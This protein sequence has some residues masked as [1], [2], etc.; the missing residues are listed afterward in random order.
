MSFP[1]ESLQLNIFFSNRI[2]ALHERL[3]EALYANPNPFVKRFVIVPNI[4]VKNWL[5]METAK[6]LGI[7]AGVQFC[8]FQEILPRFFPE[9]KIPSF[10]E[11]AL[12]VELEIRKGVNE[13]ASMLMDEQACWMPVMHYL[14]IDLKSAFVFSRKS[15]KRL[16]RFS[17]QIA[18]LFQNYMVYGN[19][20][21]EDWEGSSQNSHW[22]Q[23]LWRKI[24][25]S[26]NPLAY[27]WQTPGR[28][29]FENIPL[30]A[31][32]FYEIHFFATSYLSKNDFRFLFRLSEI[33]PVN[34]YLLSPCQLFWSD[35]LTDKEKIFLF[36]QL[37][38]KKVSELQEQALEEFLRD[39]N[40]LLVNFGRL[41]R[42]MV[43]HIEIH[44]IPV[45]SFYVLPQTIEQH[46]CYRSLLYGDTFL[47]PQ[48]HS[49]TMLQAVQA[50]MVLMRPIEGQKLFFSDK[51]HSIQVHFSPSKLREVENLYEN[52]VEIIDRHAGDELPIYP[53][54]ILVMA[55]DIRKYAPF[56]KTV[57][58]REECR[59][60][61]Q[62]ADLET[63]FQ[64]PK[65]Q[66]FFHLLSLAFGR[67]DVI[68]VMHLFDF[69]DFLEKHQF[70]EDDIRHVRKW[71]EE[72]NVKWGF[73]PNHRNQILKRN[74]CAQEIIDNY[75]SGTWVECFSRLLLGIAMTAGENE[76][77]LDQLQQIPLESI[78]ISK[79]ELAGKW[80]CLL[81][82]LFEDLKKLAEGGKETWENWTRHLIFIARKYAVDEDKKEDDRFLLE[83]L[84]AF[85]QKGE[86][87]KDRLFS[88]ETVHHHL[89]V[90][91]NQCSVIYHEAHVSAVRFCSM[92]PMRAIPSRV[93]ILLGMEEGAFPKPDD[94]LSLNLMKE[95]AGVG[96]FP[97]Q[98]DYDRF[99]F[100]EILLSA[101]D[102]LLFSYQGISEGKG[103]EP[104]PSLVVAE[105][106]SYLDQCYEIEGKKISE[107]R[108]YKHPLSSYDS[109]YFS[110]EKG[111]KCSSAVRYSAARTFYFP[112][113]TPNHKFIPC[114]KKEVNGQKE[115]QSE[116]NVFLSD[117][118][119][120][121]RNPI[122]VYFNKTLGMYLKEEEE[123][124]ADEKFLLSS[125]DVY[126]MRKE[127][128]YKSVDSTISLA[129][130]RGNFPKGLFKTIA[131]EKIQCEASALKEN[132][133]LLGVAPEEVFEVECADY[134]ER[135]EILEGRWVF[136]PLEVRT[137]AGL[138]YK[139]TGVLPELSSKG[140]I[141]HASYSFEEVLKHWPEFLVFQALARNYGL[142]VESSL[143][144][145]KSGKKS[146]TFSGPPL[147]LLT[148]YLEYYFQA[149]ENPSPL[150]PEWM[151]QMLE[152]EGEE[153]DEHI[154]HKLHGR[155][156]KF[157]NH[158][159]KWMS[160]GNK[161][162]LSSPWLNEWKDVAKYAFGDLLK[163]WNET[164]KKVSADE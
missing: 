99:L 2:E 17:D 41:G 101:R 27:D 112:E 144:F 141:I 146:F 152:L 64:Y 61:V 44:H 156:Q 115:I 52:L 133:A 139:I 69:S 19:K 3:Q 90:I 85:F 122:R 39:N 79:I 137:Q 59:L 104:L 151:G 62:M 56:I 77:A 150:L 163:M 73:D 111:F 108:T 149:Q 89:E 81:R 84:E 159:I 20:M 22:Q 8:T 93:I 72:A 74:H 37:K 162:P 7:C 9:L 97:G 138:V 47:Q 26:E 121:A 18:R 43:E 136:P 13:F 63:S 126:Q 119:S 105:L 100:L 15:E 160:R 45:E 4:A 142:P 71:V 145:A 36:R 48:D 60:D 11:L 140:L 65:V 116:V 10:L 78:E 155:H 46:E 117:L 35:T 114:F 143:L 28:L 92:L 134:C 68:S 161:F 33:F 51:D 147:P 66:I 135:P 103:K 94:N 157:Y 106:V 1:P 40:P 132:L 125:L 120:F 164:P 83:N 42:E 153:L 82:N 24:F 12:A 95:H 57:F 129:K 29:L 86:R 88:Y 127:T 54:D 130:K 55:P 109:R 118:S 32:D 34:G 30:V 53:Q 148:D 16:V 49:L 128:L 75:P 102:Y 87:F 25:S 91:F 23:H 123:K 113:K 38:K 131:E 31:D 50:D 124:E 110:K 70:T 76:S 58:E 6:H 96:Y 80:I 14:G 5:M 98:V 107:C 21:I 158:Y 154:S 67:W